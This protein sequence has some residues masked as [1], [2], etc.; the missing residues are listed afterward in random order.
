MAVLIVAQPDLGTTM[1]IMFSLFALLIAGGVSI[2]HL[3]MLAGGLVALALIAAV[4]EPYRRERL[5]SFL[6]PWVGPGRKRAS[7]RCRR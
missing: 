4:L 5:T 7:S 1:V 2:R 3:G 6:D